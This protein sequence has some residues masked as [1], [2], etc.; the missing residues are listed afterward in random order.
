MT[1]T[2]FKGVK[3]VQVN[4][5]SP[6]AAMAASAGNQ[7]VTLELDEEQSRIALLAQKKGEIDLIYSNN[8]PGKGGISIE[9]SEDDRIFFMEILGLKSVAREENK[10][11]RT[12]HYRG[13]SFNS[14]YFEDGQRIGN[15]TGP[16]T[17]PAAPNSSSIRGSSTTQLNDNDVTLD[18]LA[19]NMP[20]DSAVPR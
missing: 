20:A 11:Y 14:Q 13:P 8:G 7:S 16:R 18:D 5:S 12:E 3:V 1:A 9:A 4:R 6:G 15:P 2:L 17:A 10:P 19:G